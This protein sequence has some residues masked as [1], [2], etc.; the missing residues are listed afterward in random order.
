MGEGVTR[1]LIERLKG[2]GLVFV[3]K[4]GCALSKKGKEYWSS[5]QAVFPKSVVLGKSGLTLARFNAALIVKGYG[6]RVRRGME[7]RDAALM[8]GAEGATT[9]VFKD[10]KLAIPPGNQDIAERYPK[11]HGKLIDSL[12]PEENDAVVIGCAS[13]LRTAEYGAWAAAWS[14]IDD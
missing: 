12:E 9:L 3:R 7:Q 10:G 1:T 14:L 2:H 13:T 5:L 11:I 8:A 4:K 6:H